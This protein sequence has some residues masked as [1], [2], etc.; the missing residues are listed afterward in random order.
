[1]RATDTVESTRA[2]LE[3]L[4]ELADHQL[5]EEW[6]YGAVRCTRCKAGPGEPCRRPDGSALTYRQP[7]DGSHRPAHHAPRIDSGL[8]IAMACPVYLRVEL[9]WYV[10][11]LDRSPDC[12]PAAISKRLRR[13]KLYKLA[14]RDGKIGDAKG[15]EVG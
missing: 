15:A 5:D 12:T 7:P 8:R 10:A 1:M 2:L 3:R 14:I 4:S 6:L 9:Q 13:S 11:G